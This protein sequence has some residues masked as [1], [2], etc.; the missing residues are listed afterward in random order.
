M[1]NFL[2]SLNDDLKL[3]ISAN[4]R[5]EERTRVGNRPKTMRLRPTRTAASLQTFQRIR[6]NIVQSLLYT[7]TQ[8]R[9]Y[10]IKQKPLTVAQ[11]VACLPSS[12][13]SRPIRHGH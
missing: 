6:Q 2:S 9:A 8:T 4:S 1:L 3:T 7:Y 12:A 11:L 10:I 5:R 13:N